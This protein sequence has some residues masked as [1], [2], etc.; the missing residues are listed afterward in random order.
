[1]ERRRWFEQRRTRRSG[2]AS[3]ALCTVLLIAPTW[4]AHPQTA[5]PS[6][7]VISEVAHKLD[8][9]APPQQEVGSRLQSN[10]VMKLD[11]KEGAFDTD[12][13]LA[14]RAALKKTPVAAVWLIAPTDREIFDSLQD[15][16]AGS[17]V[18]IP[19][20]LAQAMRAKGSNE[21][22]LFTRFSA[23]A[24][25][26]L[27]NE[28]EGAGNLAGLG[29]YLDPRARPVNLGTLNSMHG[30]VAPF[31]YMRATLIDAASGLVLHTATY[32]RCRAIAG[33]LS[34]DAWTSTTWRDKVLALHTL[35][36]EGVGRLVPAVLRP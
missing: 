33:N 10:S 28:T 2:A 24:S 20:D 7:A 14:A 25:V 30:Y 27:H 8:V 32:T 21:L 23:P 16:G 9:V 26:E 34:G 11:A 19:D 18:A 35:L 15:I 29:F 13:L 3:V 22:L 17:R 12:V 36:A 31:V 1:M 4:P 5:A 6:L